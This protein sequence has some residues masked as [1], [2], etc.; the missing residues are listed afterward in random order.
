MTS[1]EL[2]RLARLHQIDPRGLSEAELIRCIQRR[3]GNFDCFASAVEGVC[4]QTMCL[5]RDD[6]VTRPGAPA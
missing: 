6:C 3:E 2:K 5:W 4:D 1:R